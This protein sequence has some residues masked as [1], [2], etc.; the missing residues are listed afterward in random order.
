MS[1]KVRTKSNNHELVLN[2][3]ERIAKAALSLYMKRGFRSTGVHDVARA[4]HMSVGNLYNYIGARED[5]LSLVL[6]LA[7]SRIQAGL[8]EIFRSAEPFTSTEALVLFIRSAY[9]LVDQ[10]QD[11]ISFFFVETRHLS[12]KVRKSPAEVESQAIDYI[13]D[14]LKKG[15]ATGEFTF[16]RNTRAFAHDVFVTIEM[17]ALRQWFYKDV[18]TLEEQIQTYTECVIKYIQ[19]KG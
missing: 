4:S 1:P 2:Q 7:S 19:K 9:Q 10:N 12:P 8:R 5:I 6:E 17:W 18:V 3:R 13:E 16:E 14:L 15:C 11:F